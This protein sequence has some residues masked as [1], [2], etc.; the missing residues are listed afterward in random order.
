[1]HLGQRIGGPYVEHRGD[2]RAL[3]PIELEL[4]VHLIEG[5]GRIA[6][7]AFGAAEPKK[8]AGIEGVLKQPQDSLL[9]ASLHVNEDVSAADQI[10][11][12]ERRLPDQVVRGE[13]HQIPD[14][15]ADLVMPVPLQEE[16]LQPSGAYV[17]LDVGWIDAKP[18]RPDR[19]AVHVGG[20][21]LY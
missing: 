11:P 17:Q 16:A 1:F 2:R 10:H 7:D 19:V 21:D 12:G 6:A 3:P 20:E 4:A 8:A 14:R 9:K 15:L 5:G 18:S 13:H